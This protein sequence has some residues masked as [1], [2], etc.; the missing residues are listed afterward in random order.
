MKP[1]TNEVTQEELK[2]IFDQELIRTINE[3]LESGDINENFL[4]HMKN[5]GK[6]L[7]DYYKIMM[8]N[9]AKMM[10]DMVNQQL[11]P[12]AMGEKFED[13]IDDLESPEEFAKSTPEEQV[14][15]IDDFEATI[16]QTAKVADKAGADKAADKMQDLGQAA[17]AVEKAAEKKAD[18]EGEGEE[19][20]GK[21]VSLKKIDQKNLKTALLQLGNKGLSGDKVG[22]MFDKAGQE[23]VK[24]AGPMAG[25]VKE[26]DLPVIDAI[27]D[28][29]VAILKGDLSSLREQKIHPGTARFLAHF[30]GSV[31][32]PTRKQTKKV[33]GR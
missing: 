25:R 19:E 6:G 29:V 2:K 9:Y 28:Q 16:A 12:S 7:F 17:Q 11:I 18:E 33:R 13:K 26:E 4:K 21:E 8:N 31:T 32:E 5:A 24:Q 30:L 14:A 22:A 1:K 23:I 20:E 3:G 15:A 10:D 27:K